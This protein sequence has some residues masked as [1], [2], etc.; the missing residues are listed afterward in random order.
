MS[1]RQASCLSRN[2]SE[3]AFLHQEPQRRDND[4]A[5][6]PITT[7]LSF[8]TL[9]ASGSGVS[10][11]AARNHHR[12]SV[13]VKQDTATSTAKSGSRGGG[14]SGD[15]NFAERRHHRRRKIIRFEEHFRLLGE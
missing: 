7:V 8:H 11:I 6:F 15:H 13:K 10:G 12:N 4:A 1:S 3:K 2:E 5:T 9:T 14:N